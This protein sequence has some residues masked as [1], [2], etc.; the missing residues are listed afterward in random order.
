MGIT[1]AST[2]TKQTEEKRYNCHGT[3]NCSH[4]VRKQGRNKI[5]GFFSNCKTKKKKLDEHANQTHQ[6]TNGLTLLNTKNTTNISA[7]TL[8]KEI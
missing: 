1:Q 6:A 5:W 4:S 7:N 2:K 8:E 3:W